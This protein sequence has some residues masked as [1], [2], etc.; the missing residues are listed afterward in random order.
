MCSCLQISPLLA[1]LLNLLVA[2]L[3]ANRKQT[4]SVD[5]SPV[6]STALRYCKQF[7]VGRLASQD[8]EQNL[9]IYLAIDGT[10]ESDLMAVIGPTQN[11][12][13]QPNCLTR[14]VPVCLRQSACTEKCCNSRLVTSLPG[15]QKGTK[16]PMIPG[17]L[18]S[19][20]APKA[21]FKGPIIH[22][23]DF[24]ARLDDILDTIPP[25]SGIACSIVV[26]GGKS[27]QDRSIFAHLATEGRQVTLKAMKIPEDSPL[28]LT[29]S[30]FWNIHTNDGGVPREDEFYSLANRGKIDIIAP[31]RMLGYRDDGDSVLKRRF[32]QGGARPAILVWTGTLLYRGV[33]D[34]WANYKT[35]SNPPPFENTKWSSIYKGIV[36][37][38]NILQRDFTI[39]GPGSGSGTNKLSEKYEG[40]QH[41]SNEIPQ[42][43]TNDGYSRE[44]IAHWISSYF[45][46]DKM[47]L[48]KT[49]KKC[50][51]RQNTMLCGFASV[52]QN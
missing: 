6:C 47:K 20:A 11:F 1:F 49:P 34:E 4:R 29:Y 48:P 17:S 5:S 51:S 45:L 37:P 8:N 27:A 24:G 16:K 19:F 25:K 28:H 44:V 7:A 13:A 15:A 38:K 12:L 52:N 3:E 40:S 23:A 43:T 2:F 26:G 42:L 18:N 35:L 30:P 32:T 14:V 50:C 41:S 22:S 9:Q 46:G 36:P 33:P 10:R 39:N 21:N 31:A